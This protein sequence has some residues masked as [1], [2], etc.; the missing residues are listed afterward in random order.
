MYT[1]SN[2]ESEEIPSEAW[3]KERRNYIGGSDVAAI[4][5]QSSFKTPLQVW[6]RKQGVI[7]PTQSTPIMEF[8]NVFEPVMASYFED[9]TGLK[10]RRVNKPF[11]HEEHE[12]LRANIDRQILNTDG[13]PGTGVLELKTTNSHRLNALGGQYPLEW[14]FQIQHYLGLTG[15]QYGYL[16]IYER[17]T[18]EFYEPILVERNEE[19][20][21]EN[22]QQLIEWWQAHMVEGNRPDPTSEEDLLI[23]YPDSSDGKV[24]EA[25][26]TTQKLYEE[27][28][29]VR[30]EKS[31]LEDRETELK[32]QL[33]EEIGDGERLVYGGHTLITWKSHTS[34]RLDTSKL[35]EEQPGVYAD[36]QTKSS[37][38]RFSIK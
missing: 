36:Y 1:Q 11:V 26:P 19:F 5:Q 30:G 31:K 13:V 15:Y 33:K 6:L 20:I 2:L 8:G 9:I 22:T 17:D 16:F 37:Y 28:K 10:T 25:S 29:Q 12:F 21:T 3:V 14:E 18:C 38:R 7:D 34:R 27:L 23:L 4:L 24:V 32:N 35:R